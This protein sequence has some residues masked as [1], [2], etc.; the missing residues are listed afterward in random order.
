[1]SESRF[2]TMSRLGG[3]CH[4]CSLSVT[5]CVGMAV[6]TSAS[7]LQEKTIKQL[8]DCR[9]A[10]SQ[11]HTYK[12]LQQPHHLSSAQHEQCTMSWPSEMQSSIPS[13]L[14]DSC[15][16]VPSGVSKHLSPSHLQST[17]MYALRDLKA[18]IDFLSNVFSLLLTK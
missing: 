4:C 9:P 8:Y 3:T 5:V 2:G 18:S 11:Q 15:L 1:M 16:V 6:V 17:G 13:Q 10:P 7:G 12:L 14:F